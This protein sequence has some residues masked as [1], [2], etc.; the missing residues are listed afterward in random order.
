MINH[1][2]DTTVVK[3]TDGGPSRIQS[4]KLNLCQKLETSSNLLDPPSNPPEILNIVNG[5]HKPLLSHVTL[6]AKCYANLRINPRLRHV[7]A[8]I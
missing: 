6:I 2:E 1:A 4:D 7:P 5:N 8:G 3:H